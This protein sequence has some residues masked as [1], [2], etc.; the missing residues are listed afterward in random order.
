MSDTSIIA[1]YS[2]NSYASVNAS[3]FMINT[4]GT[5]VFDGNVN[6]KLMNLHNLRNISMDYNSQK[7][8]DD[9]KL[10]N[11]VEFC[12]QYN[13][14]KNEE[15]ILAEQLNI[16]EKKISEIN[17]NQEKILKALR[18]L[19]VNTD[20][21][22]MI[23]SIILPHTK[24]LIEK[25]NIQDTMCRLKEL[26]DKIAIYLVLLTE[27]KNEFFTET[28]DIDNWTCSICYDS[29]IDHVITSCG[30]TLC[31][32]CKIK[33]KDKCFVCRKNI[34]QVIKLFTT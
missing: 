1:D 24:E 11:T 2:P 12:T 15:K 21:F 22:E 18:E 16:A 20:T 28:K 14:F 25:Y 23:Q 10:P 29:K 9:V 27:V 33:I 30:H 5:V 17:D 3:S 31:G 7:K 8:E 32:K 6:E 19:G 4:G 34:D 26:Q 13:R